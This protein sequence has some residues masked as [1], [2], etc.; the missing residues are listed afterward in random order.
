MKLSVRNT[1]A[2]VA[3][4][5]GVVVADTKA[6]EFKLTD[7]NGT[8][9]SLDQYAGKMVVLEWTNYECPFVKKF[10]GSDTM[11]AL[12][13]TYTE[14]GVVWLSICSSAPGKQGNFPADEWKRRIAETG[15]NPTAV[16]LD[17]DGKVGRAFGAKTTPHLFVIDASGQIVYQGAI[18]D[19]RSTNPKDIANA[20][21]YVGEA[22]DA[23]LAGK[24]VA[25]SE[26]KPYGC[27]VKY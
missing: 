2:C 23:L 27:S 26:T 17:E 15:S 7:V 10:Y 1:I 22:L 16:L 3:L 6:P 8:E 24:T 20:R 5:A 11:Q 19:K 18:D 14:K 12:Q 25:V 13:K 21:N 9:H 4:I